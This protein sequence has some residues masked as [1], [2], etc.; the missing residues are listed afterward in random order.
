MAFGETKT[1]AAVADIRKQL[2]LGYLRGSEL[3][4]TPIRRE[5]GQESA[6]FQD[7]LIAYGRPCWKSCTSHPRRARGS[8]R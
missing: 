5:Q 4:E 2:G 6:F 8:T 3:T 7:A 1:G